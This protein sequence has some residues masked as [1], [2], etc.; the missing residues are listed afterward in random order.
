[1]YRIFKDHDTS[2]DSSEEDRK[3]EVQ[4]KAMF[5]PKKDPAELIFDNG[6]TSM[7]DFLAKV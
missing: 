6:V 7:N 1:M 2:S 4:E 3:A 5:I